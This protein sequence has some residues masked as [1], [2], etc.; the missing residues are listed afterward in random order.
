MYDSTSGLTSLPLPTTIVAP[1]H[2]IQAQ[3][4]TFY[5]SQG[6]TSDQ[7]HLV[8]KLDSTAQTI[9]N[10]FGSSTRGNGMLDLD[11]PHHLAID[12]GNV[13]IYVADYWNRRV[14]IKFID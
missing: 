14:S 11:W 6:W 3:D 9:L 7:P 12:R 10:Q 13:F 1:Q 2:A 4:G 5:V 8:N